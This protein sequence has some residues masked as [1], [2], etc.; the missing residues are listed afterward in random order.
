[1]SPSLL[2]STAYIIIRVPFRYAEG[3]FNYYFDLVYFKKNN[4]G[5]LASTLIVPGFNFE[6]FQLL[7]AV[8]HIIAINIKLIVLTLTRWCNCFCRYILICILVF[9]TT[10]FNFLSRRRNFFIK[11]YICIVFAEAKQVLFR[12]IDY[13]AIFF[14]LDGSKTTCRF[15]R[16]RRKMRKCTFSSR[17]HYGG[18]TKTKWLLFLDRRI[19]ILNNKTRY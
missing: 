7:R 10:H 5:L 9:S 18:A 12:L 3:K 15:E 13:F 17:P 2:R 11:I 16:R 14:I 1:M 8:L 6:I 4:V 19:K